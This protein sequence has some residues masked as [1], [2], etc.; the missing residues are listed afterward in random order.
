MSKRYIP[1]TLRQL[2]VERAKGCCEYCLVH[3]DDT[4]FSHH[5]DHLIPLKHGGQTTSDNLALACLECNRRKGS[6]LAALDPTDN[7]ITPLFNPRLH[8]WE[9]HFASEGAQIVGRTPTG[10]ATVS[11]LRLNAPKRLMQ[12]LALIDAGRYPPIR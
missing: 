10:R 1:S 8:I 9:A 11:L 12:R 2:V 7:A 6:D 3:Q 5:I 4:P